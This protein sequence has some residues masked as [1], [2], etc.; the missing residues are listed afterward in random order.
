[1]NFK[2]DPIT[3][4]QEVIFARKLQKTNHNQ[5]YFNHNSIKQVFSRKD[6]GL[7]LDTKL[8]FQE[9]LN[10]VLSK[11]NKTIGLL[12]KFQ[13][14]LPRQPLVASYKAFIRPHLDYGGIIYDQT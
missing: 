11:V 6:F 1:M 7:Y 13:A 4:A 9:D 8:N 10:P 5:I 14:F 3:Q 2:P 12:R